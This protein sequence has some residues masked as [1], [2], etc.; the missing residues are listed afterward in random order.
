LAERNQV[1]VALVVEP[2]PPVHE[3]LAKIA[4]MCDR[5]A[6]GGQPEPKEHA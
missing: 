2:A 4:E 3:L 5:S 6:E 1:G